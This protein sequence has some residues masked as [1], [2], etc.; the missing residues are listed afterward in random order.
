MPVW[1]IWTKGVFLSTLSVRRATD[2]LGLCCGFSEFLSTLSV[3]RAT[4]LLGLCCGF[5]EFLSTLSVRRATMYCCR[6][7]EARLYFYPR[8]P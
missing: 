2:L 4:D 7:A 5:S 3:R 6:W 1:F 8:S